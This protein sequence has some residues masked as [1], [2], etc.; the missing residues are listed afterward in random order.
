MSYGQSS[1]SDFRKKLGTYPHFQ[2]IEVVNAQ[3]LVRCQTNQ[4]RKYTQCC[5]LGINTYFFQNKQVR[6]WTNLLL[7]PEMIKKA[8]K[9]PLTKKLFS[10][11]FKSPK[12][13]SWN[14]P[15]S[16]NTCASTA[17][18]PWLWIINF[19]ILRTLVC[20]HSC[21]T[22]RKPKVIFLPWEVANK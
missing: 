22:C 19:T 20:F 18:L 5:I 9:S 1:F 21:S 7:C 6:Q 2:F 16:G 3:K 8:V 17:L 14:V 10:T 4:T 12:A 15:T 13:I 11:E